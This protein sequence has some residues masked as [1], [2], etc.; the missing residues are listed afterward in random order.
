[1]VV[2]SPSSPVVPPPPSLARRDKY[3]YSATWWFTCYTASAAS[4]W[5]GLLVT[6]GS[7]NLTEGL[8]QGSFLNKIHKDWPSHVSGQG[9]P[10]IQ[11]VHPRGNCCGFFVS[12]C[13]LMV[14]RVHV[15][16]VHICMLTLVVMCV[17]V[18]MYVLLLLLLFCVVFFQYPPLEQQ[19]TKQEF[20]SEIKL[21]PFQTWLWHPLTQNFRSKLG[22]FSIRSEG[23]SWS[24][25]TS[26]SD[27]QH[28]ANS[29]APP[30]YTLIYHGGLWLSLYIEDA[31]LGQKLTPF[32]CMDLTTEQTLQSN[33]YSISY[34]PYFVN[35]HVILKTQK[36]S[37][38][39][40]GGDVLATEHEDWVQFSGP[41]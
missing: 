5:P 19:N 13:F 38:G 15:C 23:F 29:H 24:K 35:L 25:W 1:M 33:I 27:A 37:G 30:C 17:C 20:G 9:N 41:T 11:G 2:S 22:T 10:Q 31:P 12:F 8:G 36:G 34:Y 26:D 7:Q 21:G 40:S 32:G 28:P 18:H 4:D 14:L 39:S 6:I 16:C 3:S